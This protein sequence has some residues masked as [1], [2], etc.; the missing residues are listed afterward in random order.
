MSQ[1]KTGD[2]VKVHYTGKLN[3]GQVFDTSK[4][5]EPLQFKI[6]AGQ[7]IPGFEEGVM[8]MELEQEKTIEIP[9][10]KAYG[11]RMDELFIEVKNEQL[12][13]GL[14]PEKGM[15]LVTKR[16]DGTEAIVKVDEV[17]DNSIVI[18]AN[19]PL[20]GQDLTF[21]VKLVEIA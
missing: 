15:E 19:H 13:E 7:M 16:Q 1:V 6:G 18:D 8:G 12:P 17:K 11:P 20:A 9:S 21:D 5:R 14:K 4:D 2:T 3:N 10:E